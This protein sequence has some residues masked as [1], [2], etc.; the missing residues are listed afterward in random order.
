MKKDPW[1]EILP[2]ALLNRQ[3]I[4]KYVRNIRLMLKIFFTFI[5]EKI[6]LAFFVNYSHLMQFHNFSACTTF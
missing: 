3:F 6:R 2:L 5:S 4:F 1:S